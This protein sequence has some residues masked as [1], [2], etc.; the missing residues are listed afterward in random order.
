MTLEREQERARGKGRTEG[1][2]DCQSCPI[3]KALGMCDGMRSMLS[4]LDCSEFLAHFSN[5]RREFLLGIKSL[6]EEMIELEQG[7]AEK[8]KQSSNAKKKKRRPPEE[9]L[10]RIDIE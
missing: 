6:L 7:K 8:H 2:S 5:A 4:E 9:K 10:T 1:V 3:A